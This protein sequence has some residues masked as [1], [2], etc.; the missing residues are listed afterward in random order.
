[1]GVEKS[2]HQ[3]EGTMLMRF[4]EGK[5]ETIPDVYRQKV[6]EADT[7]TLLKWARQVLK[8]KTLEDVFKV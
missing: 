1:M 8:S 3:G 7:D 6:L 5:F 4:L 2:V